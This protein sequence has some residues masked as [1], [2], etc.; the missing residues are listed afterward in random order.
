MENHTWLLAS[1]LKI[2]ALINSTYLQIAICPTR[3]LSQPQAMNSILCVI[4]TVIPSS[5]DLF[6][7]VTE[8]LNHCCT[9]KNLNG[10]SPQVLAGTPRPLRLKWPC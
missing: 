8:E 3:K 5:T 9:I 10:F 6:T 1:V 4:A 7:A 2:S